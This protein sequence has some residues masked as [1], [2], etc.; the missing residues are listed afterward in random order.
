[1]E[2]VEGRVLVAQV[3]EEVECM[4]ERMPVV[5]QDKVVLM[6]L[7]GGAALVEPGT[8][9]LVEEIDWVG[10]VVIQKDRVAVTVCWWGPGSGGLH[11]KT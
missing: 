9:V 8:V 1:M 11:C 3:V 4:G 2:E 7:D 6:E 5:V 10:P